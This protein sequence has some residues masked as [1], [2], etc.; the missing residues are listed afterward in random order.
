MAENIKTNNVVEDLPV[1]SID[2]DVTNNCML[3]CDYCFIGEKNQRKLSWEIGTRAIDWLI[4]QSKDR[5]KLSVALFGGEPLMEFA[6]IKRLVPYAKSKVAGYGKEIHFS[7]TTNC[8]PIN[9]EMIQFFRQHGM[10]FHTSIDGGPEQGWEFRKI[11]IDA[12]NWQRR[13]RILTIVLQ[14]YYMI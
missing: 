14:C 4:E 7:A 9:D 10:R 8:V 12:S 2:L 3:K 13:R 5:K 1:A 6:L 11:S